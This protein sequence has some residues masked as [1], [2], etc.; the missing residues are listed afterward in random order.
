MFNLFHYKSCS[1]SFTTSSSIPLL[2]KELGLVQRPW[3]HSNY[4]VTPGNVHRWQVAGGTRRRTTLRMSNAQCLSTLTHTHT[5]LLRRSSWVEATWKLVAN[6]LL[7]FV[8]L[9]SS[10]GTWSTVVV[11]AEAAEAV[12]AAVVVTTLG[13]LQRRNSPMNS[14]VKVEHVRHCLGQVYAQLVAW[15]PRPQAY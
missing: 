10:C 4:S 1:T 14:V 12:V 8:C 6:Y 7:K 11:A 2:V 5:L 3:R 9:D 15:L 13:E